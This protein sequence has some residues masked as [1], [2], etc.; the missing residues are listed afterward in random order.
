MVAVSA[1]SGCMRS[2]R[3]TWRSASSAAS[4][5]IF[6]FLI[7]RRY[8][9]DLLLQFVAFAKLLL[10]RFHLLAEIELPLASIDFSARL[11]GDVVLDFQNFEFL[12]D[13]VVNLTEPLRRID[14]FEDF[15][16]SVRFQIEIGSD[17]VRQSSG[18]VDARDDGHEILRQILAERDRFFDCR[19]HISNQGFEFD[20]FGNGFDFSFWSDLGD[21]IRLRF[22]EVLHLRPRESLHE[23]AHA[24]VGQFQHAH[25]HG[26]CSEIVKIRGFGIVGGRILLG[27]EHDHPVFCQRL[28]HSL[29]GSLSVYE[30]RNNH[31]GKHDG[32][33]KRQHGQRVG[34]LGFLIVLV[35]MRRFGFD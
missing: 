20:R 14:Q 6:A 34:N 18:I 4:P 29:D 16:R 13:E 2:R 22:V 28:I 33:R 7:F 32:F 8:C 15:L 25:D 23:N 11:R 1:A 24:A 30:E 12:G 3:L 35:R 21:E 26:N 9:V 10:N 19:L 17:Q 27:D 5:G 31:V